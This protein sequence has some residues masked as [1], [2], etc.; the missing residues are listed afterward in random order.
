MPAIDAVEMPDG[1]LTTIDNRRLLAAQQADVPLFAKV[2]RGD[3]PVPANQIARLQ[4]ITKGQR[5]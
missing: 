5:S 1:L 3:M 2:R 4:S